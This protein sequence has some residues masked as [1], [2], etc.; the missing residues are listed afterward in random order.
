MVTCC[1]K[2]MAAQRHGSPQKERGNAGFLN[3]TEADFS[4]LMAESQRGEGW[5]DPILSSLKQY[6][7][8]NFIA[9]S[10]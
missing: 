1:F 5:L 2:Y 4:G 3:K 6:K 9:S 10:S 8:G 7:K